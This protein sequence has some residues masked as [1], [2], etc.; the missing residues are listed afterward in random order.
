MYFW[1]MKQV[2]INYWWQ[3]MRPKTLAASIMPVILACALTIHA[4]K[5]QAIPAAIC[6]VFAILVQI[7]S[8][9]L[10]DY[11]DFI[12]GS[13]RSDRLGPERAVAKG[14][15]SP[16]KMLRASILL[17]LVAC[18]LGSALIYY[19]GWQMIF[20]GIAVCLGAFAYSS[21]PYPLA[22]HG[23]GDICVVVFYGIVPVGFT[24]YV[25]SL[26][27][28][29]ATTIAGVSIGI[30]AT[31]ILVANNFRDRQEDKISN[32]NTSIVLLGEQ[33]GI[34]FYLS[35]GIIAVLL[36]TFFYCL[37]MPLAAILPPLYLIAHIRTW[38]KM[39]K[40][41]QGKDLNSILEESAKNTIFFGLLL[42][43]GILLS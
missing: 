14:W 6:L 31:N 35:N 12:K 16:Y 24:Y 10:N 39:R 9:F 28:T 2:Q 20:V 43:I 37:Q 41:Y 29:I 3:A 33:F 17:I 21:G 11:Y 42:S 4:G 18:I 7:V 8:N 30:V 22:Y 19:A 32:K 15:I 26:D 34:W 25:Q 1:Q 40:I 23:L 36:T 38:K 13:D 27:W 5:F